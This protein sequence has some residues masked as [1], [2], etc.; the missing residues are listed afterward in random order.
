GLL[1]HLAPTHTAAEAAHELRLHG[2]GEHRDLAAALRARED[3]GHRAVARELPLREAHHLVAAD[4]QELHVP[5]PFASSCSMWPASSCSARAAASRRAQLALLRWLSGATATGKVRPRRSSTPW[6]AGAWPPTGSR[7]LSPNAG[8]AGCPPPG[9][10]TGLPCGSGAHGPSGRR[11]LATSALRGLAAGPVANAGTL[12]EM[13]Q[14]LQ[15]EE[16]RGGWENRV[17]DRGDS[18]RL[19]PKCL[20]LEREVLMTRAVQELKERIAPV[21]REHGVR[22]AAIFGSTARGEDRPGSDL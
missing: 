4:A 16:C 5:T 19:G 17:A 21:L 12:G 2:I 8:G 15:V 3:G 9:G 20:A 10:R 7:Q 18:G 14:P 13:S 1:G 6:R 11:R 22:R